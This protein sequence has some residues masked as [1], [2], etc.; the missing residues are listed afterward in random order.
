MSFQ[1]DSNIIYSLEVEDVRICH[2]GYYKKDSLN[3]EQIK[4][5]GN[6]DIL[7]VPIGGN[8]TINHSEAVKIISLIQPSIII[9][10]CYKKE[11][12]EQFLKAMGEKDIEPKDKLSIQ[13]KNI[14]S[15]EEKAEIVI[16]EEK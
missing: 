10:M 13:K 1:N 4:E 14:N 6:V 3:E 7:M 11:S 9:P 8:K 5:I 16:L 2:L 15:S 12:L